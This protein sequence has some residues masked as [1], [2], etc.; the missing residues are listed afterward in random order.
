MAPGVPQVHNTGWMSAWSTG[1]VWE[2]ME[3]RLA[4]AKLPVFAPLALA[5][6]LLHSIFPPPY[7]LGTIITS[8][9]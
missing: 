3:T 2:V 4:R 6:Y 9:I 1:H 7:A 8:I 5:H